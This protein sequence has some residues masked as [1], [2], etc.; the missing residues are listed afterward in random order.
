MRGTCDEMAGPAAFEP[1]PGGERRSVARRREDGAARAHE[2]LDAHEA[3]LN[4]CSV[5]IGSITSELKQLV[6]KAAMAERMEPVLLKI[7]KME[8]AVSH[9]SATTEK[10]ISELA[11]RLGDGL[12]RLN[13]INEEAMRDAAR[14]AS[15]KHRAEME[16]KDQEIAWLRSQTWSARLLAVGSQAASAT[17]IVL[18]IEHGAQ[19]WNWL[20]RA[21]R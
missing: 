15:E 1:A 8:E 2:R 17:A 7:G 11:E 13:A 6:S 10:A 20:L 19:M 21:W 12:A 3:R 9:L 16:L 4:E 5:A 14:R 18:A